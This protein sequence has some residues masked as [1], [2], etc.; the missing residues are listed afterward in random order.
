M[1]GL[2]DVPGICV[3]H[4]TDARAL[5]GCTVI[6]CEQGAVAAVEIRGG[7]TGTRELGPLDPLHLAPHIHAILLSGGSAF[8]LDAAGGVMRYLE[9][10]GVGFRVGKACVPIVPAAII[11]DL[12]VG[13]SSVRPT[14]VMGYQACMNATADLVPEGNVGVGTGSTVGKAQGIQWAMKGGVGTASAVFPDGLIV[15]SLVVVNCW[16]DVLRQGR[17]I[18]GA[19][20]AAGRFIDT[21]QLLRLGQISRQVLSLNTTL[22][23][24]V[25]NARYSKLELQKIAQLAYQGLVRSIAPVSTMFDGD[26]VFAVSSGSQTA[27]LHRVGL[28]ATDLVTEAV[29]RAV[30]QASALGGIP[31]YREV[32]GL[33]PE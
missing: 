7:A 33:A 23:V 17:I 26:L 3:G 19:R 11:F 12:S 14:A 31:S 30:M 24:V 5:T 6:L 4:T 1:G 10:R 2:T 28:A 21:A 13:D 25:T 9:E 27:D 15:A 20:D 16:G 22:G 32:A 8:G 18:A 29:L